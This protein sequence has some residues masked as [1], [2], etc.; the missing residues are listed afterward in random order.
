MKCNLN[1]LFNSAGLRARGN[2]GVKEVEEVTG[3]EGEVNCDFSGR[4][5]PGLITQIAF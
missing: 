2:L 5:S 3:N 4:P 1:M